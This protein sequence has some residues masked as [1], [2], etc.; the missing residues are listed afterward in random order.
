MRPEVGALVSG[1]LLLIELVQRNWN[2]AMLR[3]L[4]GSLRG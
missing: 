1:R 4:L 2:R 3:G